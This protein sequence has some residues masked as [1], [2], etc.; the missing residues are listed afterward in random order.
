M[1]PEMDGYTVNARLT[2]TESTR[3]IPSSS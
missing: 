1:M 2:E 3:R